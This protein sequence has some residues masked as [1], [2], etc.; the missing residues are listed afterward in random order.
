MRVVQ[1]GHIYKLDN[2]NKGTQELVFFKD[3]PEK[4]EDNH[5]GILTQEVLRAV[6]DRVLYM[7][8]IVPSEYN[9]KIVDHLRDVLILFETRAAERRLR[10]C[11]DETGMHVEQ[12]PTHESGHVYKLEK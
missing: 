6:V 8:S 10:K 11:F 2:K 12:L 3:V 5:D 9:I 7:N 1:P 4:S